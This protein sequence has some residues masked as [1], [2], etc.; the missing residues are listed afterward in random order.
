MSHTDHTQ[1]QRTEGVVSP[2]DRDAPRV[3]AAREAEQRAYEHYGLPFT[4]HFVEVPSL[5]IR[6]RVVEVGTGPPVVMVSGG[7]GKGSDWLPLPP[8]LEGYTV[9][10]VDRPGGGLS[11]G[12]D[13]RSI[14]LRDQAI[15]A[16]MALFEQFGIA[17]APLIGNS[18]GGAWSLWFALE[19][20]DRV[21]MIGL[22]GCPA[23]YPGFRAPVPMRIMGLPRIGEV[24]LE[25]IMQPDNV[26]GVKESLEF[27]G[28]PSDTLEHLPEEFLETMYRM[29]ALPQF[30]WS[31]AS[32]LQWAASIRRWRG[33][34][35][36]LEFTPQE[37]SNISAPVIL[38]WGPN[39]P[40]GSVETGR[41][42]AKYFPDAEFHE[43]GTGHLPW[44]DDPEKCG[45]LLREFLDR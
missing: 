40:F 42:G 30:T 17:T 34:D 29:E 45:E 1:S 32:M 31:W 36:D 19:H 20:P 43:V 4:E 14:P 38:C 35:P 9:Y 12:V 41:A 18:N 24:L 3:Q 7:E 11:D 26:E 23:F 25:R 16:T 5:E 37:L 2:L 22:L 13:Y 6:T 39:D 33:F 28:H 8:E 27:L 15:P 44:L 10:V 21:S